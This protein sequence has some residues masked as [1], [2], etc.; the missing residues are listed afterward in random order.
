[1]TTDSIIVTCPDCRVGY[2][3]GREAIGPRGRMVRCPDCSHVWYEM[4]SAPEALAADAVD[5]E[6]PSGGRD[7]VPAVP[8]GLAMADAAPGKLLH[9]VIV[10]AETAERLRRSPRLRPAYLPPAP[11]LRRPTPARGRLGAVALAA[12]LAVAVSAVALRAPLVAAV[13]SL[14]GLFAAAGLEVNLAGLEFRAVTA[15]RRIERGAPIL[16]VEAEIANVAGGEMKV[17]AV[18]LVVRREGRQEVYSWLVEP[19]RASLAAG[20]T[21]T[22]RSRLAMPPGGGQDVELRFAPRRLEMAE[23]H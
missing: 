14:G 23:L 1:M 3:L 6:L 12:A 13:P 7:L 21:I 9:A 10:D 22:F 8:R 5:I 11:A 20:E 19:A 17:P 4:P 2:A 15:E 16:E 18:R